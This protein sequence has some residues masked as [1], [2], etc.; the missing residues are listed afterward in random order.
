MGP[1][2]KTGEWVRLEVEAAK[3]GLPAGTLLNGWA[4]TQFGGTTWM[5]RD[6]IRTPQNG[7]SFESL[8]EWDAY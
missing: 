6:V 5:K 2:P 4:F 8:A 1:L 3:V 7:Q